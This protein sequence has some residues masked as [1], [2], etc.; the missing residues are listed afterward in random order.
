[1]TVPSAARAQWVLG[2]LGSDAK[3][4]WIGVRGSEETWMRSD[5]SSQPFLKTEKGSEE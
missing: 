4:A 2:R 1:M 5:G 3:Y